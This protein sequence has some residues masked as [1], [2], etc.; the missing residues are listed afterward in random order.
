MSDQRNL[1]LAIVI[2]LAI[3]LGFQFFYEIPRQGDEQPVQQL[4][5]PAEQQPAGRAIGQAPSGATAPTTP[6]VVVDERDVAAKAREQALQAAPRIAIETP[7]L[8][9]SLSVHGARFDDLSLATYRETVAPDSPVITFLSPAGSQHPYY[10]EFGWTAETGEVVKL[11]DAETV[12]QASRTRLALDRPVTLSWDNGEGLRFSRTVAIDE[13]YLFTVTQRVVNSGQVSVTLYPYALISRT[14]TPEVSR[15]FILHEGPLGVFN[16]TLKEFDYDDLQDDQRIEKRST[17]GWI[18][19]TDKYWLAALVPDQDQ[20]FT[21]SFNHRFAGGGIDQYQ[22]D[23]IR[24]GETVPPGGT[25][26][27]VNHMFVGA[28]EVDLLDRYRAEYR[29]SNFDKAIDFGWFYFL[30]KPL[31]YVLAY[32]YGL[33]GNFALAILLLTV[34]VKLIF[35]PLANK[36]YRAMSTMK[37][38]QPE[39]QKIRERFGQ[40]RQRMNQEL[41][42]LYKRAKTNPAAGC[43]PIVI[44]IPVFFALYKVMLVSIEMRHAP[45]FGWIQDLSAADPTS[46]FNLFGLIPWDPPTFLMIGVW[47]LVMGFSMWL[48]MKL[49]PQPADPIQAKIMLALPFVFTIMLASFPAGLVIYWTW[50]NVLSIAQ[51]WVIMRREGIANPVAS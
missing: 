5:G 27:V 35:F 15:F 46:F 24:S 21:G 3:L 19:I 44:Q 49:N 22:V 51:Q 11:P 33:L 42:A 29:V 39:M 41:M 9:G 2:S 25:A 38:L 17:G 50:N 18:G 28:K 13:G 32:F 34:V 43:L 6:S 48:Q 47:P 7:R 23:Y 36:S 1:I 31:F 45:A 26:Q 40:D 20:P 14:G 10:A 8:S 12:W 4:S 37:K 16:D 30:T